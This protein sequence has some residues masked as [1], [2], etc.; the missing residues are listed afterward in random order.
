MLKDLKLAIEGVIVMSPSLRDAMDAMYDAR[1]PKLWR[2]VSWQA[3]TLGFWFTELLERNDQF[4]RWLFHV[5]LPRPPLPFG[6][7]S[8]SPPTGAF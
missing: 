8:L 1:V 4:Q 2:D 6:D 3:S 5:S 7:V